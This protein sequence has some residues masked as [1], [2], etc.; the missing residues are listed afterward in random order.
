M[1][2]LLC[3]I[4]C[5]TGMWHLVILGS[6]WHVVVFLYCVGCVVIRMYHLVILESVIRCVLCVAVLLYGVVIR[7]VFDCSDILVACWVKSDAMMVFLCTRLGKVKL[8]ILFRL[9]LEVVFL[10]L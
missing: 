9:H 1:T 7:V 6:V 5:V 2:V 3:G 8:V 10:E 4:G